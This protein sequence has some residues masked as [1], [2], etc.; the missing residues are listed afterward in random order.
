[1]SPTPTQ[2]H[3]YD[4]GKDIVSE[5]LSCRELL[6]AQQKQFGAYDTNVSNTLFKLAILYSRDRDTEAAMECANEALRIQF[7]MD[8]VPDGAQSL[9]FL[10]DLYL[11]KKR[12]KHALTHYERALSC[13]TKYYGYISDPVAKTLN[14]I[15]M[16]R[17][18]QNDFRASMESH[19]QALCILLE[20]HEDDEIDGNKNIS[21]HPFVVEVLCH[22]GTVYYRERHQDCNSVIASTTTTS[23]SYRSSEKYMTHLDSTMFERIGRAFEARGLY[24]M[25]IYFLK[26]KSRYLESAKVEQTIDVLNE[27]AAIYDRLGLLCCNVGSYDTAMQYFERALGLQLQLGC[28]AVRVAISRVYI[29]SVQFH[30][31]QYKSALLSYHD[32]LECYHNNDEIEDR[33]KESLQEHIALTLYYMG[34]VQAALCDY[35]TAMIT[36][37]DAHTIQQQLFG[38]DHLQTLRTRL[39]ISKLNTLYV[40]D[41]P[42]A[43]KYFQSII[44]AQNRLLKVDRHP[45]IAET[46]HNIGLA[47]IRQKDYSKALRTLED[48]YY[49]RIEFLGSDHPAL[50]TTLF[51]MARIYVLTQKYNYRQVLQI[52]DHVLHIRQLKLQEKHVDIARVHVMKGKCYVGIGNAD[53]ASRCFTIAHEMAKQCFQSANDDDVNENHVFFAEL[54]TEWSTLHLLKCQFDIARSYIDKALTIYQRNLQMDDEYD[55]IIEAQQILHRIEHDEMLCV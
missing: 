9:H 25:A 50:A 38:L 41:V 47:Y 3:D 33:D 12:Y 11:H 6:V 20:C 8:N 29:A 40:D 32:A 10:A 23:S 1:L 39:E 53:D 4:S 54:Y 55:G 17:L 44:S 15:G 35:N 49:M 18:L 28:T 16:V 37:K 36:L 2:R 21:P 48:C 30:Q 22:I 45:I 46:L 19:Q 51:D 43:M 14:C 52:C 42:I 24:Q 26:E 27:S 34:M 31:G 7:K 5:I 13:E